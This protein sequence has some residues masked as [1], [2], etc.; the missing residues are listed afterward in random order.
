MARVLIADELSPAAVAVL[1]SR[2]I[3]V[4]VRTGL[5]ESDL[6]AIIG[7]YDGLAVRSA[8]RVTVR[9]VEAARSLKVIGRAGIGVDNIDLV[10]ATSRGVVVM[11]TPFGNSVTTAEHTLALMLALARQVPAADRSTRAGK[12]E[13]ARF[14]GTELAGKVLG[15]IGCG[16]IGSIVADRAHGLKMRV[17]AYDPYLAPERARDLGVEKVAFGDLLARADLISLHAPLTESTRNLLDRKA[18][19]RTK[20]GVRIVNCARGGLLDEGALCEAIRSGHVAGAALDVFAEE[21]ARDSP[22]FELEEVV[23][24]PHLGRSVLPAGTR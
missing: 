21:P 16:N 23:V 4:D 12:W 24:T 6:V 20:P 1:E 22:L 11:N 10:A 7:A 15:L 2:E 13:K 18:M 3:L 9:V 5:S 17:I 19:A 14:V 8:T